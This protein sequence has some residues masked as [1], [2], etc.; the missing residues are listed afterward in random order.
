MPSVTP[1]AQWLERQLDDYSGPCPHCLGTGTRPSG[2]LCPLC[3]G[4][5]TPCDH[6]QEGRFVAASQYWTHARYKAAVKR[7]LTYL[8]EH[9]G[10]S[11]DRVAAEH[12]VEWLTHTETGESE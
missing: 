12:G 10:R 1:Y 9:I 6:G 3:D 5:G 8:A 2:T 4:L 7:D 11:L